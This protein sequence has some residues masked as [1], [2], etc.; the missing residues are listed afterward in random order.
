MCQPAT[1]QRDALRG[2]GGGE[3][4]GCSGLVDFG[5]RR[6]KSRPKE[7]SPIASSSITATEAPSD[8]EE[9]TD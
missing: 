9:K 5:A 2:K 4:S 1:D 3:G 8:D 7:P 6:Q